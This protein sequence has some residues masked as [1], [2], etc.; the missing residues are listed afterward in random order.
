MRRRFREEDEVDEPR[1]YVVREYYP[2]FENFFAMV[3]DF[4]NWGAS[5][6]AFLSE[7]SKYR[8]RL[9]FYVFLTFS[10]GMA[11]L[12]IAVW[13]L[14]L[15]A[16]QFLSWLLGHPAAASFLLFLVFLI[17]AGFFFFRMFRNAAKIAERRDSEYSGDEFFDES[18]DI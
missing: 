1:S 10:L 17:V 12:F 15:G 11:F 18:D 4:R 8:A 2:L 9:A 13:F 6:R 14:A 16:Y 5:L 3:L 7:E